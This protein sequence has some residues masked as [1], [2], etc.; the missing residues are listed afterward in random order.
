MKLKNLLRPFTKKTNQ[1]TIMK[2]YTRS[3]DTLI[4]DKK[5]LVNIE[6]IN[7]M[8]V[9]NYCIRKSI[10]FRS[11]MVKTN[12]GPVDYIFVDESKVEAI[13]KALIK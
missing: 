1:E 3:P 9:Q 10:V 4:V 12:T 13:K 8:K 5:T 2:S 7:K 11:I 6:G